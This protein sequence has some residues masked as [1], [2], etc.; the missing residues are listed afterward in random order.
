MTKQE[1]ITLCKS[2]GVMFLDS[3]NVL[4]VDAPVGYVLKGGLQHSYD[5][6][7]DGWMRP[8]AYQDIADEIVSGIVK[9]EDPECDSCIVEPMTFEQIRELYRGE[10][11]A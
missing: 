4:R 11:L 6:Y 1:L 10:R 9:C 2:V 7:L 3:G 8:D 5:T